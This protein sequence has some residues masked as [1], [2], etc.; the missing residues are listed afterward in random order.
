MKNVVFV[1]INAVFTYVRHKAVHCKIQDFIL[2]AIIGSLLVQ[3][4]F[5]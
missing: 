3:I 5:K 2:L 4:F 1:Y